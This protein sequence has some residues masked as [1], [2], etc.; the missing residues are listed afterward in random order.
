MR[1][2]EPK[3]GNINDLSVKTIN[4]NKNL[5]N[6][7]SVITLK[8]IVSK[9]LIDESLDFLQKEELKI[10]KK[11]CEDKRG[12]VIENI[13]NKNYIKYFEHP[14]ALNFSLFGR[15]LTSNLINA[16][17]GLKNGK[18]CTIFIPLNKTLIS[19]GDL[20]YITNK[21][22]NEYSHNSSNESA[23]SLEINQNDK[24]KLKKQNK[25]HEIDISDAFVHHSHSVHY[26]DEVPIDSTRTWAVRITLFGLA[27][28]IKVG[29]QDWYNE[30]VKR[31]RKNARI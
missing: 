1:Q 9:K 29:H 28:H 16:Y 4:K 8:G 15:F 5:F 27:D 31:N 13:E 6:Q 21:V 3:I 23:F 30:V 11:Y 18:A 12:L 7:N 26:A 24:K 25:I 20:T 10:I 19:Q 2:N 14:L 22:G 17:Y